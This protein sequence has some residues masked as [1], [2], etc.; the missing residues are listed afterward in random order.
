MGTDR[1]LYSTDYPFTYGFRPGGFPYVDTSGGRARS[2]LE[3]APFTEEQKAGTGHRNRERLTGAAR[4][5][6]AV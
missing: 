3:D 6:T 4:H 5:R 2:F 1:M